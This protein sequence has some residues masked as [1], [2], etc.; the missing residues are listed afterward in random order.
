VRRDLEARIAR[1][2][3]YPEA[4]IEQFKERLSKMPNP[5]DPS[6]R[7]GGWEWSCPNSTLGSTTVSPISLPAGTAAAPRGPT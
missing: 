4:M 2:D 1:T 3:I 6:E 7:Y 5:D